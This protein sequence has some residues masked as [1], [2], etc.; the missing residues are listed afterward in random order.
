VLLIAGQIDPR[1]TEFRLH[2][3]SAD[4]PVSTY[5]NTCATCRTKRR[6]GNP[7]SPLAETCIR[8]DHQDVTAG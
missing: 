4:E 2:Y 6:K 3:D 8:R 1:L 7:T 5:G